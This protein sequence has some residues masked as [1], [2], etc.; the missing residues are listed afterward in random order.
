[1]ILPRFEICYHLLQF[2]LALLVTLRIDDV[3]LSRTVG[4][5]RGVFT[6]PGVFGDL[7]DATRAGLAPFALLGGEFGGSRLCGG[8]GG[9]IRFGAVSVRLIKFFSSSFLHQP[10]DVRVGTDGRFRRGMPEDRRQC[11]D[12]Q[13]VLDTV[14]CEDMAQSVEWDMFTLGTVEHGFS[15][16]ELKTRKVQSILFALWEAPKG[17]GIHMRQLNY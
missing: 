3:A 14:G 11:L 15:A 17:M 10:R 9:R 8:G 16:K 7:A 4:V 5:P 1:M 12:I 13:P 2:P 6:L